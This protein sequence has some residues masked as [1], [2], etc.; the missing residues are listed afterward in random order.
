MSKR[1]IFTYANFQIEREVLSYNE[2]VIKKFQPE[3]CTYEFLNY[4]APDGEIVPDQVIDHGLYE[5]FTG[6]NYD[7]VLIIDVDCVPLSKHALEYTFTQAEK[8]ILIGN[9]QRSNHIE[10]NMHVYPAPSCI[11]F[12]WDMFEKLGHPRFTP[13]N[14]G[15]IGE[16]LSY[17]AES[18]NIEIELFLPRE[19]EALPYGEEKP[20]DLNAELPTYGIGTTFVNIN[21]E[22]MFYHL[23][24]CRVGVFNH[25]FYNKCRGLL[26][27]DLKTDK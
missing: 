1:C 5:L 24:Q 23:F 4:N 22:E 2:A 12:T 17:I 10:N 21:G 18:K 25:Y 26:G 20:W 9:V 19:Y 13:T 6:R 7:T 15:D 14:R 16:E 3:D 8:G 27:L 11:C